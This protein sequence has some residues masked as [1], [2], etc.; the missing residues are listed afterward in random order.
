MNPTDELTKLKNEVARLKDQMNKL[1]R[2]LTIEESETVP[3]IMNLHITCSSVHL[4]DP[5]GELQGFISAGDKGAQIALW[6]DDQKLRLHLSTGK[7]GRIT[8]Y[9]PGLKM[10]V[11]IGVSD[12]NHPYVAVLDAGKPRAVMK[13]REGGGAVSVVH[14]DGKVRAT[15]IS[16][17]LCGEIFAV[18]GDMRTA[19]KISSNGMKG[20]GF[21]TVNHPNGKAAVILTSTDLCGAVIVQDHRSKIVASLPDPKSFGDKC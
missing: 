7:E 21:L 15:M 19:V 11:D 16:E 10:G 18:D 13:S 1:R 9:Q 17:P 12:D 2:F 3:G 14:D 8:F 20:G 4:R 6:G 5:E